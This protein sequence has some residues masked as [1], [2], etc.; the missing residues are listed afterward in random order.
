M[1]EFA[2][3]FAIFVAVM[4]VLSI[5]NFFSETYQELKEKERYDLEQK[6]K[7]DALA[8]EEQRK[9]TEQELEVQRQKAEQDLELRKQAGLDPIYQEQMRKNKHYKAMI[10]CLIVF[11][12]LIVGYLIVLKSDSRSEADFGTSAIGDEITD[13]SQ[14][15]TLINQKNENLPERFTPSQSN[16]FEAQS[17]I[18][19][20]VEPIVI[21]K[22]VTQ[23]AVSNPFEGNKD[24]TNLSSS[25]QI[26]VYEA[27][28]YIGENTTVC[29]EVSQISQTAKATYINFGGRYPKHKFS[30]VMWSNNTPPTSEGSNICISGL[31][32]SYKGTPQIVIRSPENQV[33]NH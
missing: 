8:L 21:Q 12:V 11:I 2:I 26:S 4:I 30:A 14:E 27:D 17:N 23:Q 6:K 18:S 19:Q 5:C 32:E 13:S 7:R 25:S 16:N 22:E 29:G 3:G 15:E 9:K 20:E 33:S 24:D 28:A 1:F 31:I 10:A